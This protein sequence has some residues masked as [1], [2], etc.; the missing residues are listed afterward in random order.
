MV[1]SAIYTGI[2]FIIAGLILF[3]FINLRLWAL[4]IYPIGLIIVGVLLILF[5]REEDKMEQ[6]KDIRK[7]KK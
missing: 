4:S 2:L 1:K 3:I 5:W 6:R 7:R